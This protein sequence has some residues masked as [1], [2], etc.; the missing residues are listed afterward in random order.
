MAYSSKRPRRR[1]SA[2]AVAVAAAAITAGCSSG[3]SGGASN[4][5]A[6]TGNESSAVAAAKASVA[7]YEQAVTSN[8]SIEPLSGDVTKLKGKTVWYVPIGAAVPIL[9]NFGN[10]IQQ[11]LDHI[12]VKTHVCDGKFLP[13]G[14]ASCLTEAATQGAGG[15]ITGY[16]DYAMVPN[17]FQALVA[18]NIPVLVAGEVPDGG[19]TPSAKIAFDDTTPGLELAQ[20]ELVDSVVA[21]SNG[22]AHILFVGVTD[23]PQTKEGAAYVK[24]YVPKACPGCTFTEIDYN[25]AALPKV[26][27]QVSAAL[28]S[29]PDTTY[30]VAELD[31]AAAGA[32]QGIKTA[33]SAN[34][35]KLASANGALDSLQRVKA[36]DV[37][38]VD[39]GSSAIY[40]GWQFAD[41]LVRMMTG[42]IPHE[43]GT[44]PTRIF[45][46]SSVSS[47]TLTPNA[48]ATNDWYGD[49]SFE[50][51][52]LKA[53]GV[54]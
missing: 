36:G 33:G 41:G 27:S 24:S 40:A 46:S 38:F 51:T 9:S 8:P 6:T 3:S 50:Q 5:A 18:K 44:A 14:I 42:Q 16:V 34:K 21:D 10:G 11:A 45:D 52:F 26:P 30:V 13:T 2:F 29:H 12:G 4:A 20:K 49:D 32:V 48:Y 31:A 47:L 43:S 39:V 1:R 15:V 19:V 23:S 37:Q 28:I 25:T 22:K 53:W 35:V 54:P 7:K 17:A